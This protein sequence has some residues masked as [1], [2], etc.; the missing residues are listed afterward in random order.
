MDKILFTMMEAAKQLTISYGYLRRLVLNNEIDYVE[1]PSH[2]KK[3]I[4]RF[5]QKNIDDF[6][7]RNEKNNLVVK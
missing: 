7:K 3:R 6:K 1:L 2:G 5:S 4:I